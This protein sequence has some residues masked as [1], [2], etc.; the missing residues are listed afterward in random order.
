LA[1]HSPRFR[2]SKLSLTY[3]LHVAAVF[4]PQESRL[5][6]P[7]SLANLEKGTVRTTLHE[8]IEAS[9]GKGLGT[10]ERP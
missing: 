4:D 9:G 5:I 3:L 6:P 1:F 10:D 8:R 2:G 7:E